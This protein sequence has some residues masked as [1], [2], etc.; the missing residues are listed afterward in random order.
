MNMLE[1]LVDGRLY[2]RKEAREF[3]L[4]VTSTTFLRWQDDGLLTPAKPSGKRS[5]RVYYDGAELRA[6]LTRRYRK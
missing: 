1:R 5:S 4:N 2:T 6:L 3:G